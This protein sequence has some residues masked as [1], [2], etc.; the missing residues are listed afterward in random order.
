MTAV[1]R[2]NH[3]VDRVVQQRRVA[4]PA[5][6]IRVQDPLGSVEVALLAQVLD[7]LRIGVLDEH[8]AIPRLPVEEAAVES[9]HVANRD[10]L[11]LAELE[12]GDAVRGGGVHDP[13]A[14]V[15]AHQLRRVEHDERD[16]LREACR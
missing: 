16:A 10:A 5:E 9:D 13:G 6:R 2:M 8:A 14:L 15:H 7:D 11:A 12:V 3:D 1:V 4:A